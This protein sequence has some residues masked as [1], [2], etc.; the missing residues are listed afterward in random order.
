MII[1]ELL[2]FVFYAVND[3][4]SIWLSYVDNIII[5]EIDRIFL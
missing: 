5:I 4:I 2:E 3:F 1:R